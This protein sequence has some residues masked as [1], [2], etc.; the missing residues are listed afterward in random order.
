[1]LN[2]INIKLFVFRKNKSFWSVRKDA[3]DPY[4]LEAFNKSKRLSK[5]IVSSLTPSNISKNVANSFNQVKDPFFLKKNLLWYCKTNGGDTMGIWKANRRTLSFND[6]KTN[7]E[8]RS[9]SCFKAISEENLNKQ[10]K[11]L[12]IRL[13]IYKTK[14][15]N[16]RND[17]NSV[18]S[19]FVEEIPLEVKNTISK[20]RLKELYS[21][22]VL[23]IIT[24][25]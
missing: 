21:N 7:R 11:M 24:I 19:R 4:I 12:M 13:K 8:W 22:I 15:E 14:K 5:K 25:L 10:E 3:N 1:M 23:M 20:E 9:F 2:G 6:T 17:P 18:E 16:L